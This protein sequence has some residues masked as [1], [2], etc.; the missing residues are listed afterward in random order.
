MITGSTRVHSLLGRPISHSLSPVIFNTTFEKLGINR[1]Y[2]PFDVGESDLGNAVQAA[3]T[4][5]FK[6]FNVTMPYKTAIV[7]LLDGLDRTAEEIG[8]VNTVLQSKKRLIGY[9]T[10]GEGAQLAITAYGFNPRDSRVLLI[11]GGGTARAIVHQLSV[12]GTRMRILDRDLH[13][14]REIAEKARNGSASFEEL[15]RRALEDGLQERD[16]LI[17]ATPIPTTQLLDR[18]GIPLSALEQIGWVFDLAYDKPLPYVSAQKGRISPLEM[19]LQQAALSYQIWLN[20]EAPIRL[21][22]SALV[23][24]LG[25]D[26]R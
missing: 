24:H 3:R 6:G 22:R 12:D 7:N 17:N 14:A 20:E 5:D 1:T 16:L 10:D 9:N 13:R 18:Y 19:L 23:Q 26:W 21:M 4:L 11:G 8:A 25:R 15:S 2:I